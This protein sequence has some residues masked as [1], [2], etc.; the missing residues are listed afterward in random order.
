MKFTVTSVAFGFAIVCGSQVFGQVYAPQNQVTQP[1]QR[2]IVNPLRN[3][4]VSS[5]E[6]NNPALIQARHDASP[7]TAP[8]IVQTAATAPPSAT[9]PS[10]PSATPPSPPQKQSSQAPAPRTEKHSLSEL[11]TPPAS[12]GFLESAGFGNDLPPITTNNNYSPW[13]TSPPAAAVPES[14]PASPAVP[15]LAAVPVEVSEHAPL[16]LEPIAPSPAPTLA[17]SPTLAPPSTPV[18]SNVPTSQTPISQAPISHAAAGRAS[19]ADA[20]SGLTPQLLIQKNYPDEVTLGAVTSLQIVLRNTGTTAVRDVVLRDVL[21][22][23]FRLVSTKPTASAGASSGELNWLIS[24]IAPGEQSLIE[25]NV[26]PTVEGEMRSVATVSFTSDASAR[27]LVT[28]PQLQV[29]VKSPTGTL[30][31]DSVSLDFVVSNPGTGT[32]RNV[33]LENHIP[34]GLVFTDERGTPI[35]I[36]RNELGDIRPNQSVSLTLPP[37]KCVGGGEIVNRLVVR[38]DA[39]L[40]AEARTPIKVLAPQLHLAIEG[41]KTRFLER[42]TAYTLTVSNPGTAS[43]RNVDLVCQLPTGFQFI[44]TDQSGVYEPT[45]HTVHWALEELPAGEGGEITLT[46]LPVRA[47]EQTLAFSGNGDNNVSGE[48]KCQTS[49]DGM[50]ATSFSV[51]SVS[52]LVEVGREA[53]YEIRVTNRGTKPSSGVGVAV[54]L[55]KGMELVKAEAPVQYASNYGAIQFNPLSQLDPKQEQVYRVAARCLADGDHR[56]SV[57]LTADDL[58][59]PLVKE[60]NT[61]VISGQ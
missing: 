1:A 34:E 61:R 31:G 18:V 27:T 36:L 2:R 17:P 57:K 60:E 22:Q 25:I 40:V 11:P 49:I 38:G 51:N 19:A 26:V 53:V 16:E 10:P 21:P 43:A 20:T 8:V 30:V 33:V 7:T 50:A 42:Q 48:A 4:D 15:K 29:E 9:P 3:N 5:L 6:T 28:R 55:S 24:A 46:L 12:G 52:D 14:T 54:Q 59:A 35:E 58:Q 13:G 45:R 32:A 56:I 47:G 41:A 23:G 44:S 37:L 39:G